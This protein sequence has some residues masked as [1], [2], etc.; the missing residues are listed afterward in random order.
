MNKKIIGIYNLAN[1]VTYLGVILSVL[2]I[3]LLNK[4]TNYSIICLALAGICDLFDGRIARMFKRTDEEKK[5]GIEIDSLADVVNFVVCP[6]CVLVYL[7]GNDITCD[8]IAVI[9]V[10]AGITRLAWFNITTDGNTGFYQ[11]LPV[12]YS[13]LFISVIYVIIDRVSVLA[14]YSGY[15]F[16]GLYILLAILFVL[17]I[18][19]KK[20][21]GVWYVI[22]SLIAIATIVLLI[23]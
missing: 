23:V 21:T 9:Y 6:A 22:F 10:L 12:T 14:S 3:I 2:A 15:I 13:A 11:G 5:Y 20:P 4:N 19:I 1:S 17:N 7:C 18:K 16:N 8:I